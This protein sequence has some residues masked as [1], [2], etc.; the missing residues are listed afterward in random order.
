MQITQDIYDKFETL[1]NKEGVHNELECGGY[2]HHAIDFLLPSTA[3]ERNFVREDR[4]FFGSSDFVISARIIDDASADV[5]CAYIWELK[6]PQ[7]YLLEKDENRNRFRPTLDLVKAENQLLHYYQ[8]A[9]DNDGFRQRF[10]VM[11]RGNIRLGGIII[12]RSDKI[13]RSFEDRDKTNMETALKVRKEYFYAS[14]G[15]RLFNWD[16]LLTFIRPPKA[17]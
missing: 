10:R 7:C 12:G 6:A 2:L 14:R 8:E 3:I 15:I 1:V 11:D 13:A 17:I 16:R 9:I 5:Q 4:N